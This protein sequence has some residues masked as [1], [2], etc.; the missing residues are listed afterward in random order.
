MRH[1]IMGLLLLL[2]LAGCRAGTAM[3]SLAPLPFAPTPLVTP[4]E[5][6]APPTAETAVAEVVPTTVVPT[7]TAP[8]ASLTAVPSTATPP[9]DLSA[10]PPTE[11]L[12]SVTPAVCPWPAGWRPHTVVLGETVGGLAACVGAQ[13][14]EIVAANCLPQGGYIIYA[15]DV[16][17]LPPRACVPATAEGDEPAAQNPTSSSLASSPEQPSSPTIDVSPFSGGPGTRL[18]MKLTGFPAKSTVTLSFSYWQ[19]SSICATRTAIIGPEGE[20]AYDQF[21]IPGF[22]PDG[23]LVIRAT[24]AGGISRDGMF[25]VVGSR[26]PGPCGATPTPPTLPAPSE[27]P[28][29]APSE[30]PTVAPSEEP[31]AAPSEEPTVAPSEEPTAAPSEEPTAAPSEEPTVAPPEEPTAAPSEEPTVA[32]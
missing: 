2:L 25:E 6:A 27:E 30:E 4:R 17:A 3:P 16:L 8:V 28:T 19:Q 20:L 18:K 22:F 11:P 9:L 21:W 5:T 32:P 31:T 1:V 7:T 10:A 24:G 12:L 14:A 15:G 29:V 13:V 23:V 26:A